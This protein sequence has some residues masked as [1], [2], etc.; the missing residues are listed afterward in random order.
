MIT[1]I[2]RCDVIGNCLL[3]IVII[4]LNVNGAGRIEVP[5]ESVKP[6]SKRFF[7][8]IFQNILGM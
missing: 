4:N 3:E 7:N 5:W 6:N 1:V 2:L 8:L